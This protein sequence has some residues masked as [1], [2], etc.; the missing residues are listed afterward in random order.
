M[1]Q[2]TSMPSTSAS[3]S[4]RPARADVLGQRQH[5]RG[6]RAGRMD[7]GLQVR[8]VE[9]EGV[10]ADAVDQ[11]GAGHVDLLARGRARW[12]AARAAA[13]APRPARPRRLVVG[14]ADGA[15]EPVEEGAMRFVLDRIAPAA[16]RMAGD[17]ARQDAA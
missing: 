17:E 12:P 1:R 2:A 9:V 14:G 15:A 11:R 3:I 13:S 4:A 7:D 16:R 6:H 5:R 10:R 8:V